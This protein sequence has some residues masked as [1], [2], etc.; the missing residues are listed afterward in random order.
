MNLYRK[1]CAF[2]SIHPAIPASARSL[3][4]WAT[5]CGARRVQ[6]KAIKAY[7]TAL[8]STHID[9]G[10][11]KLDAFSDTRLQRIIQG[12]KRERGDTE[13]K[14]RQ[15]I[16]RDVL[17]KCLRTLNT[18]SLA[19]AN[20]YA[21]FCLA[22]AAFLRLG[23]IT[24]TL[25]DLTAEF[26]EWHVTR[27]SIVLHQDHLELSLPASKTD[28]FRQGIC[29]LISASDDA[30]CPLRALQH[31]FLH[32]PAPPS[33]PL[34]FTGPRPFTRDVAT[35]ALRSALRTAGITGQYSGHSFRRGAATSAREN[36]L[37]DSE[38]M[39][40]GRWKSEAYRTY[41]DTHPSHILRASRRLQRPPHAVDQSSTSA[42]P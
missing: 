8:R 12:I 19:G 4:L 26:S 37:T 28:P 29:L 20:I 14:E 32:F 1:F 30:A 38:I 22:F 36:G 10:Y 17:L 18:S 6:Y 21:A 24:Y 35:D 27:R 2:H 25:S 33:A 23:E 15:P 3:I 34:F 7:I 40:L 5:D 41:I 42:P 31:L 39:M 16:R 13:T 11:N 9:Y